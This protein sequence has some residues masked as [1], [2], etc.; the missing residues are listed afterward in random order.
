MLVDG[1]IGLLSAVAP[2]AGRIEGGLEYSR[3]VDDGVL[4]QAP[5]AAFVFSL[6]QT[7][8]PPKISNSVHLQHIED[9]IA[10]VI[11]VQKPDDPSGKRA[12]ASVEQLVDQVILAVAGE[13]VAGADDVLA[14]SRGRLLGLRGG[15]AF[16]QLT[17][18]THR[19]LRK[20]R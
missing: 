5:Q 1:V 17:F 14:L 13:T 20:T 15:A 7:A 11:V 18:S 19:Y 4:P 9:Q 16:Y 12:R 3:L 8:S 2:L 6:G 10:I